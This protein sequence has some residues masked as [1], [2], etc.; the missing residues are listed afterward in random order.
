MATTFVAASS[1]AAGQR[2]VDL[3]NV[4][5]YFAS[6]IAEIRHLPPDVYVE[7]TPEDS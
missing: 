3:A 2:P 5:P 1:T 6:L 7:N 4:D